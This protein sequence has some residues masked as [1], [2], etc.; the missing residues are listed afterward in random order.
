M[1]PLTGENAAQMGAL[2]DGLPADQR[3]ALPVSALPDCPA[4]V[5]PALSVFGAEGEVPAAL[6][7]LG[8]C[9]PVARAPRLPIEEMVE[10][11]GGGG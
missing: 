3:A 8:A 2:P 5:G 4:T 11:D 9:P 6:F 10:P 7:R 1:D